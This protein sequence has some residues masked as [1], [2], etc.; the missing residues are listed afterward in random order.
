[1]NNTWVVEY[2][3]NDESQWLQCSIEDRVYFCLSEAIKVMRLEA[4]CDPDMSHRVVHIET[5]RNT[6]ALS[7]YGEE[8]VK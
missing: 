8:L 4:E 1:M 3:S 7:A 6:V 2:Y 5:R